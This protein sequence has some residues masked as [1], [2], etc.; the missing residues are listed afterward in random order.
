[1]D[2]ESGDR[3][4]LAEFTVSYLHLGSNSGHPNLGRCG[5]GYIVTFFDVPDRAVFVRRTSSGGWETVTLKAPEGWE[6]IAYEENGWGRPAA[7]DYVFL[8]KRTSDGGKVEKL[9][10]ARVSGD[11]VEIVTEI[12]ANGDGVPYVDVVTTIGPS[13]ARVD[14]V[15]TV[16]H[17]EDAFRLTLGYVERSGKSEFHPLK[18]VTVD[19]LLIAGPFLLVERWDEQRDYHYELYLVK[20]QPSPGEL[21]LVRVGPGVYEVR[22]SGALRTLPAEVMGWDVDVERVNGVFRVRKSWLDEETRLRYVAFGPYFVVRGELKLP[23]E[24]PEEE[25]PSEE[26]KGAPVPPIVPPI[27][28]RR[29]ETT[30]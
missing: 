20:A 15:A 5:E 13:G 22:P 26:K 4:V 17:A 9:G 11:T 19:T 8:L 16:T 24:E 28:G 14:W 2:L 21:Q 12:D 30:G 7:G 27:R 6:F 1:L 18:D 29:P 23:A 25:R 3:E 10:L